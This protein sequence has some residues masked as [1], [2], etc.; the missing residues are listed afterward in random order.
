[1]H[2]IT[3]GTEP[4]DRLLNAII[5]RGLQWPFAGGDAWLAGSLSLY[6]PY[7]FLEKTADIPDNELLAVLNFLQLSG[8]LNFDRR[9]ANAGA[10]F[11][12]TLPAKARV[13]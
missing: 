12:L 2:K 5:A 13:A 4:A 1:M 11:R 8:H 7:R 3:T 9:V 10:Y 6:L